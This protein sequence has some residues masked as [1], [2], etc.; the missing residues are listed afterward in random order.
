MQRRQGGG[1]LFDSSHLV[2]ISEE[3]L[4]HVLS[5]IKCIRIIG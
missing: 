2:E 3:Y 1:M 4:Y 5:K